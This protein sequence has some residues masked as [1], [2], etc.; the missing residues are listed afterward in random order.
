MRIRNWKEFIKEDL[1]EIEEDGRLQAIKYALT[2]FTDTEDWEISFEHEYHPYGYGEEDQTPFEE[3]ILIMH[4]RLQKSHDFSERDLTMSEKTQMV[5]IKGGIEDG[6]ALTPEVVSIVNVSHRRQASASDQ[7]VFD[8][9]RELLDRIEDVC[10]K[11]C[12]EL[13]SNCLYQLTIG[14][15]MYSIHIFFIK[16]ED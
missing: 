8:N 11:V 12:S 6:Q 7:T 4:H 5:T 16:H 9:E 14:K 10:S 3:I 15:S 1:E 2:E 13:G